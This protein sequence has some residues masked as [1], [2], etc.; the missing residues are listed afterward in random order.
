MG[1]LAKIAITSQWLQVGM[2]YT[3]AHLVTRLQSEWE[4]CSGASV[5]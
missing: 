3:A 4:F 5:A 2:L 1:R